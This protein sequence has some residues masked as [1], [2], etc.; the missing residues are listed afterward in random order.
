TPTLSHIF[1]AAQ[2]DSVS[3]PFFPFFEFL[4]A[5]VELSQHFAGA[6]ASLHFDFALSVLP[7]LAQAGSSCPSGSGVATRI[8]KFVIGA[9]PGKVFGATGDFSN[10]KCGSYIP[11]L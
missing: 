5:A 4:L 6:M 10:A 7:L 11:S 3:P 8:T 9:T 1:W 2:I